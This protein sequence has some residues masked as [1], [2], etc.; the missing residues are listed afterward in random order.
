MHSPSVHSPRWHWRRRRLRAVLPVDFPGVKVTRGFLKSPV[1][2]YWA[3]GELIFL[4]DSVAAVPCIAERVVSSVVSFLLFWDSTSRG[5]PP[6][7]CRFLPRLAPSCANSGASGLFLSFF[8]PFV[9]YFTCFIC[10]NL[11]FSAL[12]TGILT[13]LGTVICSIC[14]LQPIV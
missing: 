8:G 13:G 12:V 6:G 7:G 1:S 9:Y 10:Q 11:I 5:S 4:G 14:H 2:G 3:P